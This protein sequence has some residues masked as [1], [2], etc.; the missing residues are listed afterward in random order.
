MSSEAGISTV[1]SSVSLAEIM[2]TM[3][4]PEYPKGIREFRRRFSTLS[5]SMPRLPD[6]EPMAAFR[7]LARNFSFTECAAN[8]ARTGQPGVNRRSI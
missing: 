1:D 8:P 2:G 6:P 4:R 5:V 7:N 3:G